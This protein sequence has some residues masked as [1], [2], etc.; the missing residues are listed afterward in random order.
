MRRRGEQKQQSLAAQHLGELV[1][2]EGGERVAVGV[3]G[4]VGVAAEVHAELGVHRMIYEDVHV[5]ERVGRHL[6]FDRVAYLGK[7]GSDVVFGCRR[8]RH[9]WA[10]ICESPTI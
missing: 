2:G 4:D 6:L 7:Q 9:R 5:G 8:R 10:M 3:E 1:L